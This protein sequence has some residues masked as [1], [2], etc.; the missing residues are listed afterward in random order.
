MEY[1]RKDIHAEVGDQVHIIFLGDVHEGAKNMAKEKFQKAKEKIIEIRRDNKVLLV[2]MGDYIDCINH[3]DPRFSRAEIEEKYEIQDLKN[4]P[5]KQME[6][7]LDNV[8]PIIDS[9]IA[10]LYGNHEESYVKHNGSD[11][12]SVIEYYYKYKIDAE[13][14]ILGYDGWIDIGI[15]RNE[16]N[17]DRPHFKFSIRVDHGTGGGGFREG[18]PINKV[19]DIYRWDIADIYCM[20]HIHQLATDQ[21][22]K[23]ICEHGKISRIKT[24]YGCNG[25]FLYKSKQGSRGYYEGKPGKYSTIG[26]LDAVITV[27]KTKRDCNLE[28]KRITF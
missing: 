7:F 23:K 1:A 9:F 4:L 8:R 6:Y 18:Y 12:M 2:G 22:T 14:P 20:G 26:M 27:G 17:R 24:L 15:T 3:K 10:W 21:A 28:W 13:F 25:C 19:H 16:P 5:A 11:P